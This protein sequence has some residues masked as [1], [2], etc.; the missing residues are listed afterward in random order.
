MAGR[1]QH[2]KERQDSAERSIQLRVLAGSGLAAVLSVVAFLWLA[3]FL[4]WRGTSEDTELVIEFSPEVTRDRPGVP[5][6]GAI[7][8]LDHIQAVLDLQATTSTSARLLIFYFLNKDGAVLETE[9]PDNVEIKN[10]RLSSNKPFSLVDR[11]NGSL[12]KSSRETDWRPFQ[13]NQIIFSKSD[14]VQYTGLGEQ[15]IAL[16]VYLKCGGNHTVAAPKTVFLKLRPNPEFE[17]TESSPPV[18]GEGNGHFWNMQITG[19]E[20]VFSFDMHTRNSRFVRLD[21]ILDSA[22]ATALGVAAGT[23]VTSLIAV[24]LTRKHRGVTRSN[25]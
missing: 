11:N 8:H 7:F 9:Y 17:L 2:D 4:E 10:M 13:S 24:W 14:L 23:G 6:S 21:H 19:S 3:G 22:I 5:C 20:G 1:H 18:T 15:D 12:G 16:R 25:R